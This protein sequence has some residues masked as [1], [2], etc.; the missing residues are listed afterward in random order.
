L[1]L[2]PAADRQ[3][4]N[5]RAA[6][7]P[8]WTVSTHFPEVYVFSE[9]QALET[10]RSMLSTLRSLL[11]AA[12]T[13]LDKRYRSQ[14]FER[15]FRKS[16]SWAALRRDSEATSAALNRRDGHGQKKRPIIVYHLYQKA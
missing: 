2:L 5:L 7:N 1:L 8:R 15:F 16:S 10:S 13:I 4:S 3:D 14:V 6:M 11:M 9:T 12:R